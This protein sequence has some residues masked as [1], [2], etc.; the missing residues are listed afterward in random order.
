MRV[1][2]VIALWGVIATCA[3]GGVG[4]AAKGRSVRPTVVVG[5]DE[6][7]PMPTVPP[8]TPTPEPEVQAV[9]TR[10]G[11]DPKAKRGPGT[12]PVV[13]HFGVARADGVVV[14]PKSVDKDGTPL[15]L[16]PI[17]SG[18]MIVVEGRPGASGEDVGR[19]TFAH[20]ADDPSVRPDLEIQ[21]NHNLGDGSTAVC[22]RR[23]PTI[24]G[25]PA[26]NP[27][28]FAETQRISDALNDFSC[29]FETFIES[30]SSC[31]VGT[32][33]DYTFVKKDTTTQFCL[34]IAR[35]YGFPVGDTLVTV[36]L[37]DT[38]GNPGPP[39]RMRIRRPAEPPPRPK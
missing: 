9:P 36:R 31:T 23:R 12:G 26:I 32:G 27:P 17:G 38:A 2:R 13:T 21:V 15:Y 30:D 34:I 39:K 24:G 19:R 8:A 33:G 1:Q 18:F 5:A 16:S 25:I 11:G 35:A 10:G 3:G 4:C 6:T 7:T 20:V 28:S 14:E 37:R 29:R 22:D